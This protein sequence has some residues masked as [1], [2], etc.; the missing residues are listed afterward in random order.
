MTEIGDA[1][2]WLNIPDIDDAD[3]Q[4]NVG[5]I[6]RVEPF[7]DSKTVNDLIMFHDWRGRVVG[8]VLAIRKGPRNFAH[9]MIDSLASPRGLAVVPTG[10]A[11]VLGLADESPEEWLS[12]FARL[13]RSPFDGDV[14]WSIDK[15]LFHLGWS[16]RDPGGYSPNDGRDFAVHLRLFQWIENS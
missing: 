8:H 5:R 12:R 15:M 14:G 11:L 2:V 9:A 4:R 1:Y 10:A 16:P 3:C 13:D 7:A 6:L